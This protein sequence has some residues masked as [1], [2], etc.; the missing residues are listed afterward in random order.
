M[1]P[2]TSNVRKKNEMNDYYYYIFVT[3]PPEV[4]VS[5]S[6]IYLNENDSITINCTYGEGNP[7]S[8]N[9]TWERD[10]SLVDDTNSQIDT[11]PTHSELTLSGVQLND[12]G[13]YVCIVGNTVGSTNSSTIIVAVQ[14]IMG[15]LFY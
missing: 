6:R 12:S 8:F 3:D 4:S 5:H 14:G 10:G 9:V 2:L 1:S 7:S 13:S 15:R 11:Q